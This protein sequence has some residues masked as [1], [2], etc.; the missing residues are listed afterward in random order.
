MIM[1]MVCSVIIIVLAV[2]DCGGSTVIVCVDIVI[3]ARRWNRRHTVWR[4]ID[5]QERV[6]NKEEEDG[7]LFG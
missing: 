7:L 1:I 6:V 2:I 5:R 3:G 4:S